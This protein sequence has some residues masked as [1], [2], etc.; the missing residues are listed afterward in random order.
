MYLSTSEFG[1]SHGC[2]ARQPE[3]GNVSPQSTHREALS[4]S[5][6]MFTFTWGTDLEGRLA[7]RS[8]LR[9]RRGRGRALK[10]SSSNAVTPSEGW[11]L[12]AVRPAPCA[13][14]TA[15]SRELRAE[16]PTRSPRPGPS[17][18]T[19]RCWP[20]WPR[21]GVKPISNSTKSPGLRSVVRPKRS[22]EHYRNRPAWLSGLH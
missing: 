6:W 16:Q 12:A 14:V 9:A 20:G 21:V 7:G 4:G 19:W 8:A 18:G 17:S 2:A 15:R 3:G 5:G 1:A 13:R 11:G 22:C 10:G